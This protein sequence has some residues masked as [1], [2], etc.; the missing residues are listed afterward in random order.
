MARDEVLGAQRFT[1]EHQWRDPSSRNGSPPSP[2]HIGTERVEQ[3][4]SGHFMISNPHRT[5]KHQQDGYNFED[6]V[7]SPSTSYRFGTGEG[8]LF[9]IDSS[10]AK[11][12][13]CLSLAYNG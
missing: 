3:I 1:H 2:T 7:K 10:F 9:E 5:K 6:A 4:H 11:L 12:F 8:D 13:Q